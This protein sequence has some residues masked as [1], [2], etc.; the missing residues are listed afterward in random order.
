MGKGIRREGVKL[1]DFLNPVPIPQKTTFSRAV[2][3][4]YC[5]FMQVLGVG[6]VHKLFV[7]KEID[8]LKFWDCDRGF[9]EPDARK[10]KF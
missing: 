2:P 7:G 8:V 1:A 6:R 9:L 10:C 5:N 3:G 4:T